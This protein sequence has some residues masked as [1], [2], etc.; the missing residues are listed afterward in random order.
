MANTDVLLPTQAS[1]DAL[2]VVRTLSVDDLKHALRQ[3]L[4]DF[5]AMPTHVAFLCAIYPI[6]GLL[7]LRASFAYDLFPVLYPLATGFAL[8]GPIAA[9]GLYEL[10]R[11][12][13][14]GM[15][16]SWSHVFDVL[17]S[18]SLPSIAAL[19]GLL[20][21]IFGV[22]IATA[23]ALYVSA[24]GYEPLTSPVQ[25][26]HKMLGTPAGH[27][28]IV[29]GNVIGFVFAFLAASLSVISFPLLLDR[30]VGF[31]AAIYT[32]L[33]VVAHNPAIM[34]LWFFIVAVALFMGSALLF[35]GLAIVLPVLGHATWH[36]YRKAVEPD[37]SPRPEYKPRMTQGERYAA[38]FPVSLFSRY[39]KK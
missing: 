3:G 6:V 17:H 26:A 9:I 1:A 25:F 12:H 38:D 8:V 32:S 33:R 2:P 30:N 36:L 21:V 4:D 39:V 27:S 19:A 22:W 24:F 23:H 31:G 5:W 15:D 34:A 18:P 35:V 13:E 16:T 20:L 11:R 10:S 14:L 28:L 29:S 7:L 37:R